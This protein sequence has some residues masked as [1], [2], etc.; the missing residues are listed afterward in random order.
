MILMMISK[1][2][3]LKIAQ[4]TYASGRN[5]NNIYYYLNKYRFK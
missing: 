5:I 2:N 3:S 1:I 4:Q